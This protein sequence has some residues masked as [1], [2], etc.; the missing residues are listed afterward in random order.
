MQKSLKV[1]TISSCRNCLF[2]DQAFASGKTVCSVPV[3]IVN[4]DVYDITEYFER[5][6][7]PK[8]CPLKKQS[9]KI[10]FK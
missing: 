7:S 4:N 6:S 2:S 9:L 1:I 10:K 8:N 5:A 3:E